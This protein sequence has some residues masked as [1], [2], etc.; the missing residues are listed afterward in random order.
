[1]NEFVGGGQGGHRFSE[2]E[3]AELLQNTDPKLNSK[4]LGKSIW[5]PKD[6]HY[7]V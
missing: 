1:M 5:M 2:T 4:S 3:V 7:D 6:G